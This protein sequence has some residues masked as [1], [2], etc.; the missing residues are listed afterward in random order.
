MRSLRESSW[1]RSTSSMSVPKLTCGDSVQRPA[2]WTHT[3]RTL[4][5]LADRMVE[6][7]HVDFITREMG[8]KPLKKRTQAVEEQGVVHR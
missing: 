1:D 3:H 4:R 6:L 5:L 8:R 7:D 2:G